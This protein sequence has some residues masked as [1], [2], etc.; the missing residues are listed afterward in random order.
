MFYRLGDGAHRRK[1]IDRSDRAG[2]G[3]CWERIVK[4]DNWIR[5]SGNPWRDDFGDNTILCLALCCFVQGLMMA[6]Q[7]EI[8]QS[9]VLVGRRCANKPSWS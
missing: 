4:S 9:E 2:E 5:F 7:Y 8:Y 3:V 1:W 6:L